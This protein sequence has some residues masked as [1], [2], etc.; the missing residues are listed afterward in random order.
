MQSSKQSPSHREY[1]AGVPCDF[2][3]QPAYAQTTK[4]ALQDNV[5]THIITLNAEMIVLAQK[6]NVFK[7][8]IQHAELIIP[9]SAGILWARQY[10]R[11]KTSL[12]SFFLTKEQPLTGVDSIFLICENLAQQHGIAYLIGG[13][14]SDKNKTAE[15]LKEKY[16]NLEVIPLDDSFLETTSYELQ[17]N[18]AAIFVALG[19]PKQ[20]LWVEGRRTQLEQA[21]IR[22][23][24]GVGG[25]FAMISG[26]LPR[27]PKWM[28]T[29][30]LEWLWRLI[31]EPKRI[32]R[33]WNAVV[34]FPKII[35]GYPH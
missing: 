19:A 16:Q 28:R 9:D 17:T 13:E 11:S 21:G 22:I 6:D 12:L 15:I 26:R 20:T 5:L 1:I 32:A 7:T 29:A 18:P 33:I 3:S 34:I 10:A 27:A 8:A 35:S 25:A 4:D 23:A 24:I 30:H 2:L 14:E 31:L